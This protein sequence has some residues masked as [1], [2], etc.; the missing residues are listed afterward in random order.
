MKKTFHQIHFRSVFFLVFLLSA[1]QSW[2]AEVPLEKVRLA[3]PARSLSALHIRVA[4]E[5]GFYRK[6]GLDVEAIQIR[7]AV[8]VVALLSG[9]VQ[10]TASV[11][12][13]IRSAAMGAPIKVVSVALTAPFFSLVARPRYSKLQELKGKEI[14]LT[15]NPGSSNDR[16]MR[17]ILH[18]AGLDP[19]RDVQLL[20]IGD[21]PVLYSAF[22]GGRLDA[23]FISLP[24]P[25]VAEQEGNRIL[26]NAAEIIK[27]PFTGLAVTDEK[28]KVA[29]DQIKRMIKAEVEARR[30]M[31]REK[32]ATVE[33]I[34]R[35]LGLQYA[36][37]LR[38]YEL[39]LP[40]VSV[41]A[42]VDREGVRRVLEMEL[43]SGVPIKITDPHQ[44]I[45]ARIAEEARRELPAFSK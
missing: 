45:D 17:L 7:P 8:T 36:V 28:L 42:T 5:K 44:I 14:G 1:L 11:G 12:S 16:M 19:Q 39:A 13:A 31:K 22:R 18:Q 37:A 34:T 2:A 23:M 38:S 30:F 15:G 4:Q 20:Y 9:E 10:Y 43:E 6:Y 24:F 26:A 21:P 3:Y 33:V 32:E 25:V 41:E 29:Q 35:W 27:I 40:A